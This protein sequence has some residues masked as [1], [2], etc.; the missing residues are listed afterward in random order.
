MVN[1][2]PKTATGKVR[3]KP[4]RHSYKYDA[5][6]IEIRKVCPCNRTTLR[7]IGVEYFV[8]ANRDENGVLDESGVKAIAEYV[9]ANRPR[10]EG[11]QIKGV[12]V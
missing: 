6:I 2:S 4:E 12:S 11:K 5:L 7:N 3:K 10:K 1:E 8:N 9:V